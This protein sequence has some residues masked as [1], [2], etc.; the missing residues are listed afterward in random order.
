MRAITLRH[1]WPW[2]ICRLAKRV[3]NR[4]WQPAPSLLKVG[5]LLAL[6]GGKET[7]SGEVQEAIDWMQSRS[8]IPPDQLG[9]LADPS[10]HHSAIVAVARFGGVVTQSEDSWFFGP[11]GWLLED[12][13][14]LRNPVRCRG[15]QGLWQLPPNAERAL[16]T[17]LEH[18]SEAAP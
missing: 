13:V 18:G 5:D 3:E 6:H 11:Y 15:M 7:P 4:P 8:L 16:Q 2:V 17:Q 1:P 9:E 10:R 14:V 12:V